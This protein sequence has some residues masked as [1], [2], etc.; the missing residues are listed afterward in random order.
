MKVAGIRFDN[1]T[2]LNVSVTDDGIELFIIDAEGNKVEYTV[3][4]KSRAK[5]GK[6]VE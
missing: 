4:K 5:S 2:Y 6:V 3:S 1:D